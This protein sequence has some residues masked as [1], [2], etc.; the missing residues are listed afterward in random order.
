MLYETLQWANGELHCN[1][2]YIVFGFMVFRFRMYVAMFG[3]WVQFK[4]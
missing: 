4:S 3:H 2:Q 1:K